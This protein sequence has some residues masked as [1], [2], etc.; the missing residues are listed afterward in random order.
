MQQRSSPPRRPSLGLPFP[1]QEK[2]DGR[3]GGGTC[4]LA[5][6][7]R[8]TEGESGMGGVFGGTCFGSFAERAPPWVSR[9]A[10]QITTEGMWEWERGGEERPGSLDKLAHT[11]QMFAQKN[12]VKSS[13]KYN[14]ESAFSH[15]CFSACFSV[16]SIRCEEGLGQVLGSWG[17]SALH[18]H[19]GPLPSTPPGEQSFLCKCH[20]QSE[21]QAWS[22]S[23]VGLS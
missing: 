8:K 1:G 22:V 23:Q 3:R 20:P 21:P 19:A 13:C 2:A 15:H 18:I 14:R 6:T 4:G 10:C 12:T 5:P 7:S 9:A 17:R 11:R 16:S